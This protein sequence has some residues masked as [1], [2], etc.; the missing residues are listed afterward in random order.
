M[1]TFRQT[2]RVAARKL[3]AIRATHVV[4]WVSATWAAAWTLV[5]LC[6]GVSPIALL[7]LSSLALAALVVALSVA[8]VSLLEAARHVERLA[9]W[10]EKLSTAVELDE[11]D[12]DNVFYGRLSKEVAGLVEK[13]SPAGLVGWRLER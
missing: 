12:R 9:G 2:L 3:T 1:N 7:V 10:K 13:R 4:L 8:R 5:V 11:E 6:V